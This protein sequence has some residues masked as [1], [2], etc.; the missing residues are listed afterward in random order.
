MTFPMPMF[1]PGAVPGTGPL[2][3]ISGTV[4]AAWSWGRRLIGTYGGPFSHQISGKTDILYDQIAGRDFKQA[5]STKRPALV[6]AGTNSRAAGSFDGV[7]DYMQAQFT[8]DFITDTTGWILACGIIH[9]IDTDGGGERT[10]QAFFGYKVNRFAPMFK[11]SL[12]TPFGV[13]SWNRDASGDDETAGIDISTGGDAQVVEWR[14]ESGTLY[15]RLNGG[16]ETS[17]AS[18][19]TTAID[20]ELLMASQFVGTADTECTMFEMVAFDV[21]P[22]SGDR[23]TLVSNMLAWV[24]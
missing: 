19:A 9:T 3:G 12:G 1:D 6:T 11:T 2:D 7:D 8:W 20:A 24:N 4:T 23:D 10:N 13:A 15:C 22:T 18:A 16:T 21:I 5:T 14:H 17:I